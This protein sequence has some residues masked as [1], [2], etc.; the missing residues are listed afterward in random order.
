MLCSTACVADASDC[1]VDSCCSV[2]VVTVS[3]T[4]AA[5]SAVGSVMTLTGVSLIDNF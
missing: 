4:A 5:G 1:D 2:L 3:S